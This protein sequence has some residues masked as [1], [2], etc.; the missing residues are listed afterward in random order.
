MRN[1]LGVAHR[2]RLSDPALAGSRYPA[3][4]FLGASFREFAQGGG[5]EVRG[6]RIPR[7][8]QKPR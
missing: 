2:A 7:I 8:A 4:G 3:T 6:H 5:Q 1:V